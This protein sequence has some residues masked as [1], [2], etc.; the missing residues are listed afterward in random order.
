MEAPAVGLDHEARVG[1]D[2]VALLALQAVVVA[3]SAN[4]G[5]RTR[6]SGTPE[7]QS[8]STRNV[9]SDVS[10]ATIDP[11]ESRA[12]SRYSTASALTRNPSRITGIPGG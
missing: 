3:L 2:E 8:Y 11:P 9:A 10:L 6:R 12:D 4:A 5:S 1:E 7:L